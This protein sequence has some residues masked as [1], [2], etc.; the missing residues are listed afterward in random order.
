M[1][2]LPLRGTEPGIVRAPSEATCGKWWWRDA[3]PR[4]EKE[5]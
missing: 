3:S 5:G 1:G 2:V 4:G